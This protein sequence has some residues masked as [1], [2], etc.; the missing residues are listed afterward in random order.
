MG[1]T[2]V[3][4]FRAALNDA[5]ARPYPYQERLAAEGLPELLRVPTGAGKTA[6]GV[7]PWLWRRL[8]HP[9]AAVRAGEAR[10]LVFVLPLRSLVEQTAAV[11]REWTANAG[12]AETV[13][14]HV[15]M[16][17][18]DRDDDAW[19]MDPS[20]T[21]VF[22][23]TQ[24]MLL[25]R[26]LMRGYGESRAQWP[27]SFGLLHSGVQFVFDETQLMGPGLPTSAQLQGLREKMH[28]GAP[29]RSMWM[30]ATLAPQEVCTPDHREV[31]GVVELGADD[32]VGGLAVRLNAV[33]RVERVQVPESAAAYPRGVAE[34]LVARHV[35]GTRTIAVFNT[36]ERALAVQAALA[37]LARRGGPE[38]LLLHSRFRPLERERLMDELKA[39]LP[40]AGQIVVS[41]QVLEA[42][43]DLSSRVLFTEAALFSSVVQRAGRCN[44]A[45]E[46][47]EGADLL[48]AP[49]PSGRG[50][51]APYEQEDVETAVEA[52]TSLEGTWVTSTML[53]EMPVVSKPVVHPVLRRRDLLQLFDTMPDLSGADIDVS[54][55]IR[56]GQDTTALVAWRD[57]ANGRPGEREAFP[58]REEL[59][60]APVGD[61]KTIVRDSL[62]PLWVLD[63][64][65]GVWRRAQ[66]AD[67]RPGAVL[68]T[69]TASGWYDSR[70]GWGLKHRGPVTSRVRTGNIPDGMG[71]D[72]ASCADRWVDLI[73]HLEDV[74]REVG[75]VAE[76]LAPLDGLSAGHLEAARLAGRYHDLG[77]AHSVFVNTVRRSCPEGEQ[78]PGEG[79]WAKSRHRMGRHERKYFRHELISA[80]ALLH[81]DN[82]LLDGS[83]HSDLIAYLAAAHH[84]KV[85]VSVRSM[86]GEAERV[87]PRVLGVE[88]A[89]EVGPVELPGGQVLPR[90]AVDPS[91]LFLGGGPQGAPSWTQRTSQLLSQLGLFRLA[92]LEA[93]V[94]VADWRASQAYRTPQIAQDQAIA[95][96]E[97]PSAA[98]LAIPSPAGAFEQEV[99][100]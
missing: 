43:V 2:F 95:Q 52:L 47:P 34:V 5:D 23:G 21:A 88:P 79:P 6:A 42:G 63:A 87:P 97:Q 54:P 20:R 10:W 62:G 1:R 12:V 68:L 16:G 65:E 84:G 25:S 70:L 92:L 55:W 73:E 100:W 41:T 33:R 90:I 98:P 48:W 50:Q 11:V 22:I 19:R 53:Q 80:L 46:F 15:F 78:P 27:V 30:S 29:S 40:A 35:P 93:L 39:P 59:C 82:T 13:G 85:R 51:Y 94:R 58:A 17:G 4:L 72:D 71:K 26:L 8:E 56:D 28:T 60:A 37:K 3:E 14:V 66:F 61:L 86:P 44:R 99:L 7:L 77:K 89:E 74:E 75:L 32:R 9:E 24:D 83:E 81:P 18:E 49:P 38:V 31:R 67:I 36:V 57:W 76:S 91:V 96:D 45:G 69:S 64:A